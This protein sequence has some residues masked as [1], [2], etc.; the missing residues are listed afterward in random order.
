MRYAMKINESSL[1][2]TELHI[3]EEAQQMLSEGTNAMEFSSRFFGP[4]SRLAKLGSGRKER[5]KLAESK[6]YKWLQAQVADLRKK[7]S[8]SFE[9]DVEASS[10]R[11]TISVPKSLHAALK[12]E[13]SDEGI[14]L[15]ELIRLKLGFSYRQVIAETLGRYEK[16]RAIGD[17]S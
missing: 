11:L 10:G 5:R 9:K 1:S 13:A 14:S 6:L 3:Y 16:R 8:A 17:R 7:E 15:S 4:N 12:K 2:K